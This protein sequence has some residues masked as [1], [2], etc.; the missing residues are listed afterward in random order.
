MQLHC[1]KTSIKV[2]WTFSYHLLPDLHLQS[3][4]CTI[5]NI[6]QSPVLCC[7][8]PS[9]LWLG[10][11]SGASG[12]A[13]ALLS[14]RARR[15]QLTLF[16]SRVAE[17][18]SSDW[19]KRGI[20]ARQHQPVRKCD[21]LVLGDESPARVCPA[22]NQRTSAPLPPPIAANPLLGHTWAQTTG[23]SYLFPATLLKN[24]APKQSAQWVTHLIRRVHLCLQYPPGPSLSWRVA[25]ATN[26]L[27]KLPTQGLLGEQK[28]AVTNFTYFKQNT[29]LCL[30]QKIPIHN[31]CMWI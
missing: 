30:L 3:K 12:S 20:L 4:R 7:S 24:E 29:V 21:S 9:V 25:S 16:L 17:I 10:T 1:K 11:M 18:H 19:F 14:S 22:L 28:E 27:E 8:F 23:C 5:F 6:Y 13:L 31:P 26:T 2:T 15:Q